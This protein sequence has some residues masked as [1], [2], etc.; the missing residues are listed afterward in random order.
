M[1]EDYCALVFEFSM[2]YSLD[3]VR[4]A[5]GKAKEDEKKQ[6]NADKLRKLGYSEE[7]IKKARV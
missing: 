3:N 5:Y 1:D 2:N 6:V 4:Y 7:Q